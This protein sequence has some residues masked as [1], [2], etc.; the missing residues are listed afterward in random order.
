MD[1]NEWMSY[2]CWD[3]FTY[4]QDIRNLSTRSHLSEEENRTRNRSNRNKKPQHNY[5]FS[6]V[7]SFQTHYFHLCDGD[8]IFRETA[9]LLVQNY[10]STTKDKGRQMWNIAGFVMLFLMLLW[11]YIHNGQAEKLALPRWDSNL[12]PLGY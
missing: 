4:T 5:L 1:V 11:V 2:E 3:E 8:V 12:R 10:I 7:V 9:M 6:A